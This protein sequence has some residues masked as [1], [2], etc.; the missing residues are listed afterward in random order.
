MGQARSQRRWFEFECRR[1]AARFTQ[2]V[3]LVFH[4]CP[5]EMEEKLQRRGVKSSRSVR[6]RVKHKTQD[7]FQDAFNADRR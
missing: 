7:A 3:D 1:C 4:R 5:A 6:P 2:M